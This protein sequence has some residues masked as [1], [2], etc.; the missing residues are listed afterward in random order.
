MHAGVCHASASVRVSHACARAVGGA[1][2][3]H[4]RV[5]PPVAAQEARDLGH[6]LDLFHCVEA[7]RVRENVLHQL[8]MEAAEVGQPH[9][10][11]LQC[12]LGAARGAFP[13]QG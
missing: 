9:Y 3:D 11:R 4:A 5:R 7:V 12:Q 8:P 2:R 1:G 10:A 13:A 6:P